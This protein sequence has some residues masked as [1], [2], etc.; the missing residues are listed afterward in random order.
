V[1]EIENDRPQVVIGIDDPEDLWP[2][3][4]RNV[5]RLQRISEPNFPF[6]RGAFVCDRCDVVGYEAMLTCGSRSWIGPICEPGSEPREVT[7]LQVTFF[8]FV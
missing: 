4:L 6:Q 1:I 8:A 5:L 2:R 7:P 3:L